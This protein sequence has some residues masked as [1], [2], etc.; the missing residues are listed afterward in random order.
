RPEPNIPLRANLGVLHLTCTKQVQPALY[1][2]HK[3]IKDNH[4]PTIVHNA[5]D[6]LE[7]AEITRRKINDKMKDPEC[8]THKVTAL[9]TKNV[10]LKAQ[11]LNMVNSNSKDHVKSKVLAPG[12]SKLLHDA[13]GSQPR[14]ST[15]QNRILPA[16][17][18]NKMQV[19]EQPRTNKSPLRTTNR[20]DSSSRSK[21]CSKHLTRDRS[22]LMNFVKKFTGTVRFGND[23]FGAI[24]GYGDYMIGDSVISKIVPRTPQQNDVVERWNRI[25]VEAAWTMLIF[26]KALMFLEDLGKLQPTVD[27]GIFVGYAP[28]RKCYRIYNKR[29]RQIME[30]IHIQFDEPTEPM[31]HVHLSTGPAP[32]FLMPGQIIQAPVHSAGTPSS[33]TID[34]DV[35]SQSISPSSSALQ[36]HSLHQG[37]T[38][39]STFMEDNLVAPIDNNPFINVFAPEPSSDASSSGDEHGVVGRGC[40]NSLGECR[41]T[42][43]PMEG[44]RSNENLRGT[45]NW[46]LWYPKDTSM[47][48]TAYV[49][50]DHAGCQDTQRTTSES[51]QFLGDNLVS[52]SSKKQKSIAISTTEAEYIAMSGCCARILWMRSQLTDYGFVFNKIPL[53]CDNRSA[54]ALSCNNVQHSRSKHIDNRHHYIREKVKKYVV[55]LYFVTTDYQLADIFTK[56]SPIEW[57]EFLL[58]RLGMKSM[59][60]TTLKRLQEEEGK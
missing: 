17:G 39:E 33:T 20:V 28:S 54:I 30:T 52:W 44:D 25:L 43:K 16:K 51:A 23:H 8:V 59:S 1:N 42:G 18:V 26:S 24:M 31:A 14:S 50:V 57:F 12:K 37:V 60:P 3:I 48:L 58:P 35:H 40:G 4:V 55:E 53:Y 19:E 11:I 22:R 45:I 47:A 32:I 13:S 27:I 49:D 29:T 5:E 15:K 7:I 41:C 9:I 10:N 36:S 2:G 21:S 38:A 56:A 6:T 34:Q 46:G